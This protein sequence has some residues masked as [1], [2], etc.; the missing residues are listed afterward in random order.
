MKLFLASRIKEQS[1]LD[2]LSEYVGGFK[3]KKIALVPTASNGENGWEY[4]KTKKEGTWNHVHSLGAEV[5]DVV[6]ENYRDESVIKE[7][8]DKDI[9][10]VMGGMAGYLSYWMRRCK[11][12]IHLKKILDSGTLYVGSSA[13][14]M[15]MGQTLQISGWNTI[16]GERGTEGIKPM[17][18]VDFD[19][20]PHFDE[21]Y[22][23]EIK[24]KYK[25]KK[26]YL[27]KDGEEI[28]VENSKITVV[29]DERIIT[30]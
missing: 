10:W 21:K 17:A 3:N 6:L 16:D 15:V 12:D 13:G 9:I 20:F 27:L 25:G 1:T 14:A 23:E 4:Y 22:L 29:G 7:L 2:K 8:I 18:I 26:I 11:L 19:I 5:Q 28:I 30:N 24:S